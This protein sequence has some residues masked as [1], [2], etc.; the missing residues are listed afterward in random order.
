MLVR[1]PTGQKALLNA[2]R[3]QRRALIFFGTIEAGVKQR[4]GPVK[5]PKSTFPPLHA[6][7]RAIW[8]PFYAWG[9]DF[10]GPEAQKARLPLIG[11]VRSPLLQPI[12]Y[13]RVMGAPLLWHG[14]H[15]PGCGCWRFVRGLGVGPFF[16]WATGSRRFQ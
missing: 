11:S 15:E 13:E 12:G 4:N 2:L 1:T 5:P 9:F 6:P 10:G 3:A 8:R 16:A 14:R 7:S